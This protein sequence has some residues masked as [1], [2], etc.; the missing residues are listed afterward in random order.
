MLLDLLK[1]NAAASTPAAAPNVSKV[2][3]G[4]GLLIIDLLEHAPQL[5]LLALAAY[6]DFQSGN[7]VGMA[8]V[9]A[10]AAPV[11]KDIVDNSKPAPLPLT[12]A[13]PAATGAQLSQ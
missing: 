3:E 13:P 10:Q 8:Q 9:G 7:V 2:V 11:L 6:A 4:F 1:G 5:A 12:P